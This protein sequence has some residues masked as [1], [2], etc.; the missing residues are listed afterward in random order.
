MKIISV[1]QSQD[2]IGLVAQQLSSSRPEILKSGFTLE[3]VLFFKEAIPGNEY[4]HVPYTLSPRSN[5]FEGLIHRII[6]VIHLPGLRGNPERTY[7]VAAIGPHFPGTFENYVASLISHGA[8]NRH[9]IAKKLAPIS[10][11]SA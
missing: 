7:P 11:S 5:P 6:G 10:R 2:N 1:K 3:V 4:F 8:P 9:I